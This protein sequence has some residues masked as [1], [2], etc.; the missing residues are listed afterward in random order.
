MVGLGQPSWALAGGQ[1]GGQQT[2]RGGGTEASQLL[3]P[4][5]FPQQLGA[6][7][8]GGQRVPPS[9]CPAI[10]QSQLGDPES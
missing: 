3:G 7:A 5:P 10:A 1:P 2:G 6:D 9:S 4:H 8:L